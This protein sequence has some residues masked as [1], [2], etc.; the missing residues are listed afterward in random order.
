[1]EPIL[2]IRDLTFR[3]PHSEIDIINDLS[4]DVQKGQ[5]TAILGP[6]GSGKSTLAKLLAGILEPNTGSI[7][8]N[9]SPIQT[10]EDLRDLRKLIGIVFQNPDNQIVATTV[11]DDV[12]FG[13][14]NLGLESDVIRLRVDEA[15]TKV[16]LEQFKLMEPHYLS[17]GQKQKVA[18]AG[19][20]AMKPEIM[21]FDEATSMLDPRGRKEL[22]N[23][24]KQLN[25]IENI[26]I[27]HITHFLQ[28]TANA[29]R[30]I[31]M[32]EGKI[33]LDGSP[34]FVF[35][36]GEVLARIGLEVPLTVDLSKRLIEKNYP[37]EKEIVNEEE[38]IAKLWTF[39]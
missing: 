8:S 7:Y 5:F 10:H 24:A 32:N 31:V 11:E 21:I 9:G 15:L 22:L 36:H 34:E 23:T 19:I 18:I 13:L 29:D 17:G 35:S 33:I 2:K 37:L 38:L 26:T 12:A 6:N 1:M 25:Q 20:L 14:E 27:L 3:Y 16:G 4:L 39:I 28:E 30:V